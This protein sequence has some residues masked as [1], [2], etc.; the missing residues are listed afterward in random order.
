MREPTTSPAYGSHLPVLMHLVPKTKG[1]IVELGCGFYSTV[2][3]HWACHPTRRRLVTIE[4]DPTWFAFAKAFE[5]PWHEVWCLEDW[6]AADLSCAWSIALVDHAPAERRWKDLVRL[7]HA[8]YVVAHDAEND[9]AGLYQ[10]HRAY[11]AYK[12]RTKYSDVQAA[13]TAIFSNVHDVR[14]LVL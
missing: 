8:E 9:K 10:Y 2:Y 5:K 11:H 12:H 7:A 4:T 13:Y 6:D 14:S 3:L 1:P